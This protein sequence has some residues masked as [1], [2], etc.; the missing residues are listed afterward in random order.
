MHRAVWP[1][2]LLAYA[3]ATALGTTSLAAEPVDELLSALRQRRMFDETLWYLDWLPAQSFVDD[4]TRQRVLFE[5]GV[6]LLESAATLQDRAARDTQLSA[7][8][9]RFDQF[10]K[11]FP[12]HPLSGSAK[13][14]RAN[15]LIE[16]ARAAIQAAGSD[17]E[18]LAAARRQFEA[19]REQFDTAE[20][21]L[22]KQLAGL[23]KLIDPADT[24]AQARKRQLSGD[25]A[26][27][28]MLRP[29]IDYELAASYTPGSAEAKRH[30]QAAAKSYGELYE[31]YRT[32]AAGLLARMWQ[33]RCHQQLGD[34][35][36]AL[37]C[38]R[39][40]T[41]LPASDETR[42]I[43]TR[44]TRYALECLTAESEKKYE[45]AIE[46]GQ[47]WEQ[48][49]GAAQGEPDA[50]AIR[51]L[52]ALAFQRQSTALPAKDPNRKR[53]AGA[54]RDYVGPVATHPGEFQK[55]ARM[56][57]VA[58]NAKDP[59]EAKGARSSKPG[60]DAKEP[61]SAEAF[62]DA[63]EGAK[64]ALARMQDAE[65]RM[66][67]PGE[68]E[69]P[70]ELRKEKAAAALTA[71]RGLQMA[72]RVADSKTS[73]DELNSAR[74]Y[75][76]FLDWDAGN[77]YDAA[78]IG[79]FLARNYP[80]SMP[81]RQGARIAL[82]AAVRL[83]SD[84]PAAD[85]SFEAARIE[86]LGAEIFQRFAGKEEADEAALQLLSFAAT[87]GQ[88]DK[89][90]EYLKKVPDSSP[91]RGQAELR[92]GQAL[93][94][95]YLR[96]SQLPAGER[97]PQAELDALKKQAQEVLEQGVARMEKSGQVDG[98]VAA[99]VFALA[100]ICVDTGQP[101]QAIKWLE[102]PKFGP[103]T[104]V[105]SG[106]PIGTR[107]SFATE[108]YKLA[109]RA[110]IAVNPQ[111]LSKAEAAMDSLE[112]LVQGAGDAK[113]AESLTAIY[114]SLGRELEQH[115]QDLRKSGR[116]KQLDEVSKAFE[117]FLDRVTK[118]DTGNSYASLNWVGQT[119]FSLGAGLD[120][121][122]GKGTSKKAVAYFKKATEAY[123][124]MLAMAEKDP[125]FK[126]QPDSL[127]GVRLR[128]ADCLSRAGDVD[129]AIKIIVEVLKQKPML[130]A[131]QVQAAETYQTQGAKDAK[132]Y[133]LA[134]L[135]SMP[136]RDGKNVIWGWSK[137]SKLTMG[138]EK[139]ADTFHQ[140]RLR[141][142]EA[143]YQYAM[144]QPDAAK[145][146]KLF[147]AAKQDLWF[148]YKLQPALGGEETAA[149]YDRQLKQIQTAMGAQP[150][151]LAE[152]REKDAA[153]ATTAATK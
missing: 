4:P 52:T 89:A 126:D 151:G 33:G 69:T 106:N 49:A 74:Y 10:L 71:R 21:D 133:G 110:Y 40:L 144:A 25:L 128:L 127:I 137:L 85:K 135:G 77:L 150:T 93:W 111:Q 55:P 138:N 67:A 98:T 101:D 131:A 2:L 130:L 68:N 81:G 7:A 140:A 64:E 17:T 119:Y 122:D 46:R 12:E 139:F 44:S 50:L 105:Q 51:Y 88:W 63:F 13:I 9:Q 86:R 35:K 91:R 26:H 125:K 76:C 47:R 102:H 36:Q 83:Y 65:A 42:T 113:S 104:L 124:R 75:L 94:S 15:I 62:S 11:D 143:R 19:A 120:E 41:E 109:L 118:R 146:G 59:G 148:T 70:D 60:K 23:P 66:K 16:R 29:S 18:Q 24:A 153:G 48:S 96:R 34:L 37:A 57:L 147:E 79:E 32:R 112:K 61:G 97:P 136:G 78:V 134:I 114:I 152:F 107:P 141:M 103:L 56:L 6:T 27:L 87:Q 117:V 92:A 129:G 80:D 121:G 39:E 8:G 149:K 73:K 84:S 30:W 45:E 100:Q 115:L 20:K 72:L 145:R 5:Q 14:Q 132:G 58:L 3:L 1:K 31:A 116:T 43:V 28:R 123:Q 99:A 54:A 108:A 95:A 53:L 90:Q 142:A 38:F 22:D 82:A